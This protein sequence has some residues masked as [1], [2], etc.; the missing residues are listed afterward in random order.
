MSAP[1]SETAHGGEPAPDSEPD[2]A[3]ASR[4]RT[5]RRTDGERKPGVKSE[6]EAEPGVKPEADAGPEPAVEP[7]ARAKPEAAAMPEAGAEGDAAAGTDDPTVEVAPASTAEPTVE[8]GSS[9]RTG[10]IDDPDTVIPVLPPIRPSA[11]ARTR[12]VRR[13]VVLGVAAVV[14]VAGAVVAGVGAMAARD[15]GALANKAF[16]DSPATAEVIGQV[17]DAVATVYSYDYKSLPASE[18]AAKA[19]ITGKF[20]TDFDRVFEPVKQLAPSQQAVL[21][22]TVRAAGVSQLQGD[23]ARLLMMVDQSGVR[24]TAKEPTGATAR[25]VVDAQKVAGRW[26][27]SEVTPE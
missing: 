16:V 2:A 7:D 23:R 9:A 25:L 12:R 3:E 18:S 11:A 1:R 17:T 27:I 26:K 5:K 24:G 22:T 15:S 10:E 4:P 21:R 19:V 20:A 13:L 6:P 8:L 14:L